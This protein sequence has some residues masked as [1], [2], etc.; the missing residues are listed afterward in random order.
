MSFAGFEALRPGATIAP[1]EDRWHTG[2]FLGALLFVV[3]VAI[4]YELLRKPERAWSCVDERVTGTYE[5]VQYNPMTKLP[6]LVTR[7]ETECVLWMAPRE[8]GGVVLSNGERRIEV[9]RT[10]EV[11]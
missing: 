10:L 1:R 6:M 2:W 9:A 7:T 3:I 4:A 8:G 11:R 5:Q